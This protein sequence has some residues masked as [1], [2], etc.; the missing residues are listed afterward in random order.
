MRAEVILDLVFS[1]EYSPTRMATEVA[2]P[3]RMPRYPADIVVFKDDRRRAP[4]ITVETSAPGLPDSEKR[5]KV[6][7][8]FGCWQP[9]KVG[10]IGTREIKGLIEV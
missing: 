9:A 6:E 3:N 1:Y 5:Q 2:V 4:Y 7:Q 8:L 10:Q